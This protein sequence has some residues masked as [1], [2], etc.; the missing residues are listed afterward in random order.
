MAISS[1]QTAEPA[2]RCI[3]AAGS[4][5][6]S[7]D[8]TQVQDVESYSTNTLEAAASIQSP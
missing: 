3:C 6:N 7:R 8:C 2:I 5:A 4:H 1:I